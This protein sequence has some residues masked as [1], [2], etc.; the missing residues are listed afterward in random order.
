MTVA[1]NHLQGLSTVAASDVK[2]RGWK[3]IMRLLAEKGPVLVTNHDQPDAVIVPTIEY[4]RLRELARQQA[5]RLDTAEEALRA[6]WDQRLASLNGPGARE[7]M[8]RLM[9]GPLKLHGQV[10][11]GESR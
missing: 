7:Q 10:K 3:G 1:S 6:E 2:K 4:E 8:D 11:A 5:Q 9:S